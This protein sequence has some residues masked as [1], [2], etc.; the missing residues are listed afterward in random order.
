MEPWNFNARQRHPKQF[1][2]VR[3]NAHANTYPFLILLTLDA[4]LTYCNP[5]IMSA[6]GMYCF[7]DSKYLVYLIG[8][9]RERRKWEGERK[10]ER[11]RRDLPTAVSLS[12]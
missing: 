2:N 1:L 8:N 9:I 4:L 10:G 3:Y 12:K 5:K 11:D 6:T 7:N